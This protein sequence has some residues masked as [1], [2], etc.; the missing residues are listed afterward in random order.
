MAEKAIT[1]RDSYAGKVVLVT[2]AY[3]NVEM[4]GMPLSAGRE[5]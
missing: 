2:G 5:S 4:P 3:S 1:I